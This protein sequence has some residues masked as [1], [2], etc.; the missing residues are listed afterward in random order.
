MLQSFNLQPSTLILNLLT[1]CQYLYK[2]ILVFFI[3]SNH[4]ISLPLFI[5]AI[6]PPYPSFVLI[7]IPQVSFIT[8]IILIFLLVLASLLVPLILFIF[9]LLLI[10]LIQVSSF[11]LGLAHLI[12]SFLLTL[13]FLGNFQEIFLLFHSRLMYYHL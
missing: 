2:I 13:L 1:S 8:F 5:F 4:L 11:K 9:Y 10:F 7:L 3:S 12:L 6:H